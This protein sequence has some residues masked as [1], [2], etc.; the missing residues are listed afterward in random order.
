V[1]E[2]WSL[3]FEGDRIIDIGKR[4]EIRKKY[5]FSDSLGG[6]DRLVCPGFVDTHMHSF[7]VATKGLAPDMSLLGWLKKYIW[8]WEGA[9]TKEKARACAEVAYLQMIRSGTTSFSDFTAVHHAEEAFRAADRFGLRGM[10][11]KTLMDRN[12]PP[13]QVEDTDFALRE[14]EKLLRKWNG[15]GKGRLRYAL[16]PR[17]A[18]TCTDELLVGAGEMADKYKVFF[19]THTDENALERKGDMRLYG[20]GSARH[21]EKLGLLNERTL[22]AHCIWCTGKELALLKKRKVKVAHCPGSNMFLASGVANVPEMLRMGIT[23]GLGTDV[24]AY[25]NF[26]MMEQMRLACLLQKV[27]RRDPHAMEHHDAWKMG[28]WMGA[29]ALGMDYTG[30]LAEGMKADILLL[31]TNHLAFSP[32]NDPISQIV[33]SAF[34]SAVDTAICDGKILMRGRKVLVANSHLVVQKAREVLETRG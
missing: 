27:H 31:S 33:Y 11:G 15:K 20:E 22:L 3:A 7:Q 21:L 9:L 32:M 30:K 16:T 23:V 8:K 10:I 2:G 28:T 1:K 4:S 17:F 19:R 6:E 12:G 5:K 14:S 24:A 29:Q 34:P 26:S 18:L 25:Y 13:E